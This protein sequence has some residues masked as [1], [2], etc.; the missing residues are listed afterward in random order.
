VDACCHFSYPSCFENIFQAHPH[1]M[2][3][4]FELDPKNWAR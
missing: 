3:R 2:A 4:G 1:F